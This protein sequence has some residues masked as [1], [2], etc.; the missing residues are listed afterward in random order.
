MNRHDP[1]GGGDNP[2]LM[3]LGLVFTILG[4]V[5]AVLGL[6]L[7]LAVEPAFFFAFGIMGISFLGMGIGFL[8]AVG[9]KRRQKKFLL[10]RG[11]YIMAKVFE[12]RPNYNV[13]VNGRCGYEVLCQYR[14]FGGT[15][16]VFKSPLVWVDPSTLMISDQVR[17]Y[18]DGDD[19]DRYYVDLAGILPQ[20]KMH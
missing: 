15:V 18:V 8:I 12:T 3:I 17:V 13:Q 14:D 7:G 4:S 9:K 10:E 2:A 20:I 5:F 1:I 11:N 16:H 6:A 19:Y